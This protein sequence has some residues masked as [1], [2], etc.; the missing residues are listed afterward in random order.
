LAVDK[1]ASWDAAKEAA[2]ASLSR[3]PAAAQRDLTWEGCYNVRDL[4]GLPTVDGGETRFGALV[5][6]DNP[7]RLTEEGLAAMRAHGVRSVVDLRDHSEISERP[8]VEL[9]H[10]VNVSVLDFGDDEYWERWRGVQ[11]TPRFYSE[12]LQR[13]ADR[14]AAAVVAVARA[15]EG[16]VLVHC[17]V[18]RDRTGLVC[19]LLLSVAGVPPD[20]IAADYALSA[21]RLAPLYEEWLRSERDPAT[22]ARLERENV[23]D[24]A[25][26][27]HVLDNLDVERYL[28]DA[29]ATSRN[30]DAIR[31]R[32]T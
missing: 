20:A 12:V 29:G 25:A 17:E 30:L 16:G 1:A 8:S 19:A 26:M 18:G 3:P 2:G 23:S 15:P 10:A 13:W 14:F 11:D 5:R 22:R 24:A 9:D 28:L 6:S 21:E 27:A 4:G 32:L 31:E 7:W